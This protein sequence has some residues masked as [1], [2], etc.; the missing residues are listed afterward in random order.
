MDRYTNPSR[1]APAARRRS[2]APPLLRAFFSPL[3]FIVTFSYLEAVFHIAEFKNISFLYPL[4]LAIPVGALFGFICDLFDERVAMILRYALSL[5]VMLIF[6]VQVVYFHSFRSFMSF[7]QIGMGDDVFKNFFG[8]IMLAVWECLPIIILL[9]LPVALLPLGKIY[10][11]P[12][13]KRNLRRSATLVVLAAA[14]QLIALFALMFSGS[15]EHSAN[16]IYHANDLILD[17]SVEKLGLLTTTRHDVGFL[18]FGGD[19]DT[20]LDPEIP[21]IVAPPDDGDDTTAEGTTP[22]AETGGGTGPED[23][24]TGT[25]EP[26]APTSVYNKID[27]LDFASLAANEKDENVKRVFEYL[28][29]LEPTKKNKYTGMFK[30]YN[31]ILICAESFSPAAVDETL[32]PTLYKLSHSGFI[33][34]NYWTTFPSNTTNG[35]YAL[36]TG[37]LPDLTKPKNDGSFIA[38]SKNTMD[39]NIGAFFNALG[40]KTRA[41]H[42][43]TA[44]YYSR[45]I[46][47]PNLGYEFHGKEDIGGLS[48]WPESDLIMMQRTLPDYIGEERFHTYYMTVSMHHNYKFGGLNSIAD[49]NRDLVTSINKSDP[50]RAY[51]ACAIELDRALEY[52]I[53]ELEEA[54][55]LDR[56]VICLSTDHYP[57]GLTDSE[58]R[59]ANDSKMM[60]DA[61]DRYMSTLILWNSAM[62]PVTV[63][64]PCCPVDVLPTLLNLFGFEFDSRLY[65]GSDI[66]S[67]A[68]GLAMISNQSFVTDKIVYNSRYEKVYKLDSSW[69]MPDGYLDAYIKIVKNRFAIASNILNYDLYAKLK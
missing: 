34:E 54:G 46:T 22:P 1:R 7:G 5:P 62:E 21:E 37:L 39:R 38:S 45:N 24:G 16:K 68:P 25:V 26:P 28:A 63:T 66:L 58:Y 52:L 41:Y 69:E 31:L 51:M 67:D 59:E 42:D 48:G 12:K 65:S 20:G 49:K 10:V 8:T 50:C 35:E 18:L 4:L 17:L 44:S 61:L 13:N 19:G 55:K 57:Y 56:T 15:G 11:R 32:T 2:A 27:S 43:H 9:F 64:K 33:F 40:I 36:L 53:S 47:H 23:T 29:A 30:D 60:Y 6:S 14:C 3:Y